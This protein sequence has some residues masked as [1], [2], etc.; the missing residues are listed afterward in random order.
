MYDA[1]LSF[2]EQLQNLENAMSSSVG[3][4]ISAPDDDSDDSD[5]TDGEN[6]EEE[7]QQGLGG[8]SSEELVALAPPAEETEKK[9]SESNGEGS[10]MLRVPKKKSS[11]PSSKRTSQLSRHSEQFSS[12]TSSNRSSS[13]VGT[14]PP[15]LIYH[16]VCPRGSN[17]SQPSLLLQKICKVSAPLSEVIFMNNLEMARAVC[18]AI[19]VTDTE[20]LAKHLMRIMEASKLSLALL[21]LMI[22]DEVNETRNNSFFLSFL[23]IFLADSLFVC[24][25][26]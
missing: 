21:E 23:F 18:K 16:W 6:V 12:R 10:S 3:I 19:T 14:A 8:I 17:L 25:M 15:W 11:Q 22:K 26:A 1:D 13:V 7:E 2:E 9:P 20:E 24:V 5:D 4:L